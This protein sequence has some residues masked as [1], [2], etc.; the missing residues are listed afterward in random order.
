MLDVFRDDTGHFYWLHAGECHSCRVSAA[1]HMS[2]GCDEE[3]LSI[4]S[5]DH[6]PGPLPELVPGLVEDLHC[7]YARACNTDQLL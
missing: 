2:I 7:G 5:S 6:K 3:T 4:N 1:K